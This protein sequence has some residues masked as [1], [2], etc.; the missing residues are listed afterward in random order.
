MNTEFEF[1]DIG[2]EIG[3]SK[4][5]KSAKRILK[6]LGLSDIRYYHANGTTYYTMKDDCQKG[7]A[8]YGDDSDACSTDMVKAKGPRNLDDAFV[9]EMVRFTKNEDDLFYRYLYN[10]VYGDEFSEDA[11]AEEYEAFWIVLSHL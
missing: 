7:Y 11:F 1:E 2:M 6:E 3:R 8:I 4:A 10:L 9:V 5:A